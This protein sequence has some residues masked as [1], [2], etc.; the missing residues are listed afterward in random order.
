MGLRYTIEY[1]K[2]ITNAAADA[3][4]R[5]PPATELMAISIVVP[6]WLDNLVAGYSD[7]AATK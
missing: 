4:S 3:L 6:S 5:R 1:K 2:G 7:D